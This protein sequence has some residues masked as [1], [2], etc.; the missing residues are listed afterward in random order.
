MARL[1]GRDRT[2]L[3]ANLSASARWLSLLS[4]RLAEQAEPEAARLVEQARADLDA[5]LHAAR[6][7]PPAGPA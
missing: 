3:V 7:R 4:T 2:V 1:S 5:V 6:R